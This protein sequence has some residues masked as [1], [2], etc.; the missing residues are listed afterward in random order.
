MPQTKPCVEC[1][2][3]KKLGHPRWCW[4]C[5]LARQ[6]IDVQVR[7]AQRRLALVPPELRRSRVPERFWP[8]GRRWCSGC[9]SFPRLEDCRG[10]RCK[11]CASQGAHSSHLERTYVLGGQPFTA[12]LYA[13]LSDAQGGRCYICRRL[14]RSKRLTVDHDHETGEVRGLVCGGTANDGAWSCNWS[15]LASLDSLPDPA[16]A[17]ERL[18]DYLREP[19]ARRLL[20]TA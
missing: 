5:W 9:Q 20:S 10:S 17:A 3:P 8:P 11:P 15:L 16:A 18:A 13:R 6:P 19:P 1:G 12:E 2:E 7:A 14:P 4:E